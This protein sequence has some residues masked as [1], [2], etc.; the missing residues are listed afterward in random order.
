VS[1]DQ[2]AGLAGRVA[3]VV[4]GGGGLGAA[5]SLALA[6]E[7]VGVAFCD[8]DD[9]AAA[10]TAGALSDMDIPHVGVHADA[11]DPS[12]LQAFYRAVDEKFDRLDIVVNVVGGVQQRPFGES[13]PTDWDVDIARNFGYVLNS[14]HLALP[15]IRAGGGGGSIINFTTIEAGRGA[16]GFAVYAGAKAATTNFGRALAVELASEGIRVNS[17]A[18][19]I[20]PSKGNFDAM[21]AKR[22]AHAASFPDQQPK[23]MAVYIPMGVPPMPEHLADAVLF[24]ASDLSRFVTGGTIHVDGGTWAASGFLNWPHGD[25]YSPAPGPASRDRLFGSTQ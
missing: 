7:G 2:R 25:G 24:L 4:G 3:A 5:V 20:T 16:A 21:S 23:A 8:V 1:F 14:I 19:D 12:Q 13:T 22:R 9:E 17:L 15:R 11:T 6:A 10:V 18:P